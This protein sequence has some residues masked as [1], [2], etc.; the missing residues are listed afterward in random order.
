MLV[1]WVRIPPGAWLSVSCECCV[2]SGRGLCDDL[3]TLPDESYRVWCVWVWS[4]IT[5][6]GGHDPEWGRTPRGKKEIFIWYI[7]LDHG[8]SLPSCF[9]FV[10]HHDPEWS[11]TPKKKKRNIYMVHQTRPLRFPSQLFQF[12][13]SQSCTCLLVTFYVSVCKIG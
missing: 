7:K 1:L 13:N 6:R 10:I 11:R 9:N 2:L 8:I 12:H 4:R 5:V 3:I